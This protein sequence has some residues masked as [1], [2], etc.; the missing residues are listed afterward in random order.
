MRS[1]KPTPLSRDL[2]APAALGQ[3]S[4]ASGGW[5]VS[6]ARAEHAADNQMAQPA[7]I[8]TK[9]FLVFQRPVK[10]IDNY[11]TRPT[12]QSIEATK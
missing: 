9:Y 11:K 1:R 8:F 5:H 10:H 3:I 6:S 4:L 2:G 12:K 7:A